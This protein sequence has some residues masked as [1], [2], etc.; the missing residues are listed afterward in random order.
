MKYFLET[1]RVLALATLCSG[2]TLQALITTNNFNDPQPLFSAHYPYNFI[3]LEHKKYVKGISKTPQSF[4]ASFGVMPFF[5]RANFATNSLGQSTTSYSVTTTNDDTTTTTTTNLPVW[6]GDIPLKINALALLPFNTQATPPVT[7][8]ITTVTSSNTDLPCGQAFPTVYTTSR[9]NLIKET[10]AL[11]APSMANPEPIDLTYIEGLLAIQQNSDLYKQS[12]GIID[13]QMTYRKYGVR[14]NIEALLFK[15]LGFIFQTGFA[16]ITQSPKL[17]DATNLATAQR[18]TAFSTDSEWDNFL[19][20]VSNNTSGQIQQF[21]DAVNLNINSF[22]KTSLEDLHF[23]L[24]WR[25]VVPVQQNPQIIP[26]LGYERWASMLVMPFA[27]I[28]GTLATGKSKNPAVL[29]SLPFGNNEHNAIRARAGITLD[30][31]NS[32]ELTGE[33]GYTHFTK[34]DVQGIRVPNNSYQ[35]IFY[36]FAVDTLEVK[37]GGNLHIA[38]GMYAYNFASTASAAVTYVFINHAPNTYTRTTPAPTGPAGTCNANAFNL[39]RLSAFSSWQYQVINFSLT[40]ETSPNTRLL[41]LMQ[42]PIARRNAYRSTTFGLSFEA[43]F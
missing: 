24:F 28:G 13:N 31:Y 10:S 8:P 40:V 25:G 19:S 39:D 18:Y 43:G 2:I 38:L 12:L 36:P 23:D 37:P 32:I 26:G 15:G 7:T 22:N 3:A 9:D 35:A 33:V 14:F 16:S 17:V 20:I 6:V 11:Y 34:Q 4:N 21:A 29:F 42:I 41:G 27:S 30:F 1:L 5:Q